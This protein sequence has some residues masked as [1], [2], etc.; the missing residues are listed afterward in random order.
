MVK[1]S[2]LEEYHNYLKNPERI[3]S[4][5]YA[6]SLTTRILR[7]YGSF[8]NIPKSKEKGADK[9]ELE[10]MVLFV[11]LSNDMNLNPDKPFDNRYE[12]SIRIR[13]FKGYSTGNL[14]DFQLGSLFKKLYYS[15]KKKLDKSKK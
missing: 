6:Q 12:K 7:K 13:E 11:K 8:D 1:D 9:G 4:D 10:K 14:S 3:P 5:A 15:A 2:L